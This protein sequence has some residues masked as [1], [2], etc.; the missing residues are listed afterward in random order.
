MLLV[1]A[2]CCEKC[3]SKMFDAMSKSISNSILNFGYPKPIWYSGSLLNPPSMN[4]MADGLHQ[5]VPVWLQP[6]DRTTRYSTTRPL[7]SCMIA[8][9]STAGP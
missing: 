4:T 1:T 5:R 7:G 6:P 8:C 9:R 2:S 3:V